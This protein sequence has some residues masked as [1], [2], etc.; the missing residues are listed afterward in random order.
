MQAGKGQGERGGERERIPSRLHTVSTEP[1][2][3]LDL[4]NREIMTWA[5]V[6]GWTLDPLSRS[7]APEK[8]RFLGQASMAEYWLGFPD[9]PS[10]QGLLPAARSPGQAAFRVSPFRNCLAQGHA[11]PCGAHYL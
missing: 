7:G 10:P 9:P 2:A 8:N 3:G 5:E 6:K 1:H 4:T 11:P